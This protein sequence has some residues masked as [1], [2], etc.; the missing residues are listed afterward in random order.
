MGYGDRHGSDG[1][2]GVAELVRYPQTDR[3]G[4]KS[5]M[6]GLPDGRTVEEA[7]LRVIVRRPWE[8]VVIRGS[9]RHRPNGH[10]V[11]RLPP[12]SGWLNLS[13]SAGQQ[14]RRGEEAE[15]HA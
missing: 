11:I 9:R 4:R 10:P 1:Q 13:K 14:G 6:E 3:I 7:S 5:H 15:P 2:L 8:A 12:S